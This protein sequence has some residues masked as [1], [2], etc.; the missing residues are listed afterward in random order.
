M[1][2]ELERKIISLLLLYGNK[3]EDFEDLVLKEDEETS[4]L[5]LEP[6]VQQARVFE[7]IYLDLQEDEMAF[8]N[9]L[10]K[11]LYYTIVEALNRDPDFKIEQIINSVNPDLAMEMSSILMDDERYSL[12]DWESKNIFPK[13]KNETIAQ[14]VSETILTLRW[15]LIEQKVKILGEE[16]MKNLTDTNREV[17]EEVMDYTKLKTLLSKKLKRPL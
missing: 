4:E 10:F 16:A 11:D 6:V 8:T 12:S 1:Q 9:P 14:L 7:K 15:H 3:T 5:I 17:L 13:K 2:Y